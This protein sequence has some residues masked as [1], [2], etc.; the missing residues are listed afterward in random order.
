MAPLLGCRLWHG[1]IGCSKWAVSRYNRYLWAGLFRRA[2]DGSS[3][4]D[5]LHIFTGRGTFGKVGCFSLCFSSIL[6]K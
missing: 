3:F 1:M 6:R 4:S 2:T 5:M